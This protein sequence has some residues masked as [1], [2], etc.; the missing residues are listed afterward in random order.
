V[1]LDR[2]AAPVVEAA[3]AHGL[4]I[5]RTAETVVR[6]LPPLTI[7]TAEIDLGLERLSAALADVYQGKRP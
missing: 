3:F 6:L 7:S 5:N 2:D 4:L 1:G